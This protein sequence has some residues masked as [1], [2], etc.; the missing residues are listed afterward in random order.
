VPEAIV[1]EYTIQ[2]I[3]KEPVSPPEADPKVP[4]L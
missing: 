4:K 1:K 2:E 3:K